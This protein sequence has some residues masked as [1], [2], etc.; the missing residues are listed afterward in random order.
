METGGH[1][2]GRERVV[3]TMA[4]S[5][6]P[7]EPRKTAGQC[8]HRNADGAEKNRQIGRRNGTHR[9]AGTPQTKAGRD[10][11]APA[12]MPKGLALRHRQRSIQ[13]ALKHR[14]ILLAAA[15]QNGPERVIG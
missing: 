2:L 13:Q 4:R 14:R 6:T 7:P 15:L 11:P 5:A 12:R 1:L 10:L 8:G 3:A 9:V